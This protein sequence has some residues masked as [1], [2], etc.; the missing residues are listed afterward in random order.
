VLTFP[1]GT[2]AGVLFKVKADSAITRP[3]RLKRANALTAVILSGLCSAIWAL[4]YPTGAGRWTAGFLAG[5]LWANGFEYFYHR[6]LL[7]A[8][9]GF[10]ARFHL[11]HHATTGTSDEPEHVNLAGS[12]AWVAVMFVLNGAVAAGLDGLFRLRMAS[13]VLLAFGLYFVVVEEIHWRIHLRRRL[14]LPPGLGLAADYHLLHHRRPNA[15][16]NVF[17][18]LF[19]WLLGT[20]HSDR[21]QSEEYVQKQAGN[22]R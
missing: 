20:A 13:G 12:P 14:R 3:T 6:W 10:Q 17:L 11:K 16:F 19:D 9:R 8:K 15:R 4:R 5:L 22:I 7:H 1:N 2:V 21:Y 18:P